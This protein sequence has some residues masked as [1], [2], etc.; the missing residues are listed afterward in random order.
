M[1]LVF[2]CDRCGA[3]NEKGANQW[4]SHLKVQ[5]RAETEKNAAQSSG[6]QGQ[7]ASQ[8]NYQR[9]SDGVSWFIC[10]PCAK[11]FEKFI[12]SESK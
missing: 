2:K 1:S 8:A 11:A 6:L 7:L 5:T 10:K 4:D 12:M 9:P 3:L